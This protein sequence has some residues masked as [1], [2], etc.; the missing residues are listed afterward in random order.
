VV[1]VLWRA[2][3][4]VGLVTVL[5]VLVLMTLQTVAA[6]LTFLVVVPWLTHVRMRFHVCLSAHVIL[7]HLK[8]GRNILIKAVLA[9]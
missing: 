7:Q 3:I 2:T 4:V 6:V 1:D 8:G 9:T 5:V